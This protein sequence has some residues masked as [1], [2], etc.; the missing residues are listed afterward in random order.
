MAPFFMCL[1][2][3]TRYPSHAVVISHG[4]ILDGQEGTFL[5]RPI[6]CGPRGGHPQRAE[7]GV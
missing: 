4:D 5:V 1:G 3:P 7:K 6:P 2:G